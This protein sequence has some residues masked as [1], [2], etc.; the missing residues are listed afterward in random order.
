MVSLKQVFNVS[1][2]SRQR[3]MQ[4]R[5]YYLPSAKNASSRASLARWT[6]RASEQPVLGVARELAGLSDLELEELETEFA[7]CPMRQ[8]PPWIRHV[9][10][11][12]AALVVLAALGLGVHALTNVGETADGI[13]R[14]VSVTLLLAGLLP[15]G[16]GL[17]SAFSG[18]HLDLSYGTTG[19]Y[20]GKL[21]EQHPWIYDAMSLTKHGVAEDYRQR[22]LRER[23]PLRGADQIMMRELV[24]AHDALE[25]VQAAR[26][27]GER[28][29]SL[30]IAAQTAS[31]EPRLVR[32]SAAREVT[33]DSEVDK[34]RTAAN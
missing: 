21:D 25:R 20:V 15:L 10:M 7:C 1:L 13:V 31:H 30:P 6:Q 17:I 14:A 2:V 12:G 22:T 28:L 26:V 23:G 33:G 5:Q 8:P 4:A 19:L 24:R 27:V 9:V 29:Q 11:I 18:L 34:P 3:L 32:V 16:A